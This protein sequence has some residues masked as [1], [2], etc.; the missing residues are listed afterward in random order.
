[1]ANWVY[2]RLTVTGPP[3][4]VHAFVERMSSS[5]P[6]AGDDPGVLDFEQLVPMP[7]DLRDNNEMDPTD[8]HGFPRWRTW[9]VAHWGTKWNAWYASI[10]GRADD[11]EVMYSFQTAWT[12]PDR[13]LAEACPRF[14]ALDFRH[15]YVEEM[16]HFAGRALWRGGE[17]IEARAVAPHEIEWAL[18]DNEEEDPA[19]RPTPPPDIGDPL[20]EYALHHAACLVESVVALGMN[21]QRRRRWS[22]DPQS[23]IAAVTEHVGHA[24]RCARLIDSVA[25]TRGDAAEEACDPNGQSLLRLFATH[26]AVAGAEAIHA[27]AWFRLCHEGGMD[28]AARET[29]LAEALELAADSDARTSTGASPS[30][31]LLW[32]VRYLGEAGDAVTA[33]ERVR[34]GHPTPEWVDAEHES[35]ADAARFAFGMLANACLEAVALFAPEDLDPGEIRQPSFWDEIRAAEDAPGS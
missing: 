21:A 32:I 1:M 22:A 5:A 35:A 30:D 24:A 10:A 23:W 17:P 14:P 33:A 31:W 9:C 18:D 8:P 11:G 7:A 15:E 12:P 27:A 13:W 16:G 29:E 34:L 6:D 19:G 28:R 4:D 20:D 26:L 2:N 3:S 25:E